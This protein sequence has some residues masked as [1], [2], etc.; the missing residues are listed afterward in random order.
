MALFFRD[1]TVHS[2][3]NGTT[4]ST[5]TNFK[6]ASDGYDRVKLSWEPVKG[7]SGYQVSKALSST[8]KFTGLKKKYN[9][10]VFYKYGFSYR[11]SILL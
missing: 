10:S 8:G 5:P 4:L 7:V 11:K 6:V 3:S 2:S 9:K 1:I